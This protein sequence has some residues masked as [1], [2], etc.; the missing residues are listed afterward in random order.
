[1]DFETPT[2]HA[3][4]SEESKAI[5]RGILQTLGSFATLRM[6]VRGFIRVNP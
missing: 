5:A 4:R 3:E 1:M 6:T 2:G